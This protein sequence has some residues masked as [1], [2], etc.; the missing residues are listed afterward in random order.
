MTLEFTDTHVHFH[1]RDTP[2]LRY[3][4]LEPGAGTDEDLGDYGAIRA[5]HFRAEDFLHE[6]RFHRVTRVVHVQAA[7]GT[8]DPV[9]E[10]RWLQAAADR[11]GCPHGIVPTSAGSPASRGSASSASSAATTRCSST[12][13]PR[14]RLPRATRTRPSA[15]TMQAS[16]AG[17]TT[18]TSPSGATAWPGWPPSRAR[19]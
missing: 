18:R 3:E 11:T 4:W 17:A 6:T 12:T 2:G 16:R 7:V 5:D 19:S 9:A 1:T 15:S 13:A 10:T 14:R 8:P